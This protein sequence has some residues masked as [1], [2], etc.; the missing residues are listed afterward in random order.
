MTISDA[1]G[2]KP[3]QREFADRH[4]G[5]V[6][7]LRWLD[8]SHLDKRPDLQALFLP[9][10]QLAREM[11]YNLDDDPQVTLGLHKLIEA[12]DCFVRA[13]VDAPPRARTYASAPAE[14]TLS[15]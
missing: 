15:P 9:F 14:V 13:G 8:C 1:S 2:L 7:A 6:A 3:L 10:Q 12:K 5:V 4:P 11:L